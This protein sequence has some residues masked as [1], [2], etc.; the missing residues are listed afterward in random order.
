M[1]LFVRTASD[2]FPHE[3]LQTPTTRHHPPSPIVEH[4]RKPTHDRLNNETTDDDDFEVPDL[5]ADAEKKL[6]V[7]DDRFADEDVEEEEE[8][9]PKKPAAKKPVAKKKVVEYVDETL[10]DPVAEKA[11]RQ[12]L[13]EAADLEAAKEL[14]GDDGSEV[15]LT[16]YN[17]KSEK[18]FIKF[19]N[20]VATKYLTPLKDS[21]FYK[22]R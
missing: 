16:T 9:Q 15:D 12:K 20:L 22:V 6:S 5:A 19:G 8:E 4:K 3:Q 1:V 14:F 18:E 17:P 10:D 21:A 13:V 11:R 2:S 7:K